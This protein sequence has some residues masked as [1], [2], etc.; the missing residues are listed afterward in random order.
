[1]EIEY[2]REFAVIAKLESFSRAAEELCISQSSLSKH[3]ATLEKEL[4]VPLLERTSRKVTVSTAGGQILPLAAQTYELQNKIRVAAARES[5]RTKILL[6]IASIPVMAQYDITGLLAKFQREHPDVTLDVCEAEQSEIENMVKDGRAELAFT[7]L[8]RESD[9]LTYKPFYLDHMVAVVHKSHPLALR[10]T[11]SPH[12][13]QGENLLFLA[14]QTGLYHLS[15]DMCHHAGFVPEITFTGNRPENLM[16]LVEHN[17][18]IALLMRGHTDFIRSEQTV[19]IPIAPAVESRI[20]L[21]RTIHGPHSDIAR[22]FWDS[23]VE[24]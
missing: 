16:A 23:I 7:R 6:K 10:E 13:L 20:C 8:D 14:T 11:I 5:S 2:L 19:T 21:A 24:L 22:E 9:E 1:M 15:R 18:G 17:M 3:I 12:D 4:G